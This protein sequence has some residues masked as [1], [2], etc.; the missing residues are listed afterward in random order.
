MAIASQLATSGKNQKVWLSALS[1]LASLK[2]MAGL[3]PSRMS[4]R[5]AGR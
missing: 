5:L 1:S 4:S 2:G 3:P